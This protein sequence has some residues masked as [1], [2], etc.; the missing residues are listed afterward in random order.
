METIVAKYG[1]EILLTLVTA[2]ALAFCKYLHR[3]LKNYKAL[4]DEKE[5]DKTDEIVDTHLEPIIADIEE[6]RR[7]IISIDQEENRKMALI[8]SSYRYRL[9]ALCKMYLRQ[10]YMTESQY[11]QL[12]EFYKLYTGLGG[13]GQ[14]KEYYEKA[15]ELP[16]KNA[17][18]ED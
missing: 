9:I 18:S 3:Q 13:N 2:G 1:V 10:G 5:Q 4:L 7:Y 15:I 16:I 12:T 6:L 17:F 14:A 11:D 8:I